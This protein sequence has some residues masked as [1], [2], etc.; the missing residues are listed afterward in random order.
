MG[1]FSIK[2]GGGEGN[3]KVVVLFLIPDSA[4]SKGGITVLYC[5]S[6]KATYMYHRH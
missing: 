5:V 1:S 2:G 6:F 4:N 3:G